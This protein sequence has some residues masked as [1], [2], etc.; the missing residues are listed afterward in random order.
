MASLQDHLI[1][2]AMAIMII[3]WAYF[4]QYIFSISW[5]TVAIRLP[6]RIYVCILKTCWWYF[7]FIQI[8]FWTLASY[9]IFEITLTRII[10]IFHFDLKVKLTIMYKFLEKNVDSKQPFNI[11]NQFL[12]VFTRNYISFYLQ[13]TNFVWFIP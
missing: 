8:S 5:K 7:N 2:M 9:F 6:Y 11:S 3:S 4:V 1:A 12:V 13:C 10:S